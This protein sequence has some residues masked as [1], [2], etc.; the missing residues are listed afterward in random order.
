MFGS[1]KTFGGGLGWIPTTFN[2][3]YTY[4]I[5][6]EVTLQI[7]I[8]ATWVTFLLIGSFNV[9]KKPFSWFNQQYAIIYQ[10]ISLYYFT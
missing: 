6:N 8:Y 7:I 3:G 2:E 4:I 9:E 1:L 10:M 5:S